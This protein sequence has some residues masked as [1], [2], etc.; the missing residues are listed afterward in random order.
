[1]LQVCFVNTDQIPLTVEHVCFYTIKQPEEQISLFE[2]YK[3]SYPHPDAPAEAVVSVLQKRH[4]KTYSRMESRAAN[5]VLLEAA[6]KACLPLLVR[7]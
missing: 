7:G 5:I 1:M 2:V 4:V 6:Q 3:E